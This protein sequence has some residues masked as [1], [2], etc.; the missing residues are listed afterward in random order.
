MLDYERPMTRI[1]SR[2]GTSTTPRRHFVWVGERTRDLDGAHVD[3][4]AADPEPD[5]AS[6]CRPNA[7]PDDLLRAHRQ[8]RPRP[9]AR[10]AHLHHPDGRRQ[11]SARRCR[12]SSRGSPARRAGHLGLRPHARQHLTSRRPAT[13]P[14]T[15]TTS[16]TRSAGFFEVHRALGHR[17]RRHPR[18][19]DRQRRHRVPRRLG[20]DPRRRP[21][22][23]RYESV[24]DPRLNHQQS[25]ELAFLVA[26]M[27][28]RVSAAFRADLLSDTLTA[29][30]RRYARGHGRT[31]RSATTSSARTPRSTRS[32]SGSPTCSVTRRGCSRRPGRWPTSSGCGCTSRPGRSWSATRWRTWCAPSWA[33][34]RRSPA[35]RRGPGRRRAAC[36]SAAGPLALM[37]TGAGRLPGQH[38]AGR[39]REHPQLRRRHRAADRRDPRCCASGAQE[40]GVAH[41][42]GRRAALERPR[43]VRRGAAP[44]TGASSTPSGMPSKGLG[45]PVGSVL[46]G[47]ARRWPRRGS[48][49]SATAAGCAR[50][51]ILAAA[52]LLRARPPRGAAGRRPRAGEPVGGGVRR[53]V[54]GRAWTPPLV[55]TNILVMDVSGAGWT[56]SRSGR[57][58][59]G[60]G[61]PDLRRRARVRSGWSGTSTS[62]TRRPTWR[63]TWCRDCCGPARRSQLREAGQTGQH[64][65]LRPHVGTLG[66]GR[67]VELGA[68]GGNAVR[69]E[70]PEQVAGEVRLDPDR[71]ADRRE[72][73][74]LSGEVGADV[75]GRVCAGGGR[76][77]GAAWR[78]PA[79]PT[80][81]LRLP[82]SPTSPAAVD[83][84]AGAGAGGGI[85][86][87]G[88]EPDE[89]DGAREVTSTA[90]EGA[91]AVA[92][93]STFVDVVLGLLPGRQG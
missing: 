49:A 24:C 57:R 67:V 28:G 77:G 71:R 15:S 30:D 32:R 68:V 60:A 1:D 56:G 78:G 44:T 25:L 12:R 85:G 38:R 34:P 35:S 74:D 90:I 42:P 52:G 27:L 41:A 2:T 11:R 19:A 31:P 63:S 51:A 14:A 13:R 76:R 55:E 73:R 43:G 46:V 70:E 61:R 83:E 6:R 65:D 59:S 26:E 36:S 80:T 8:G 48:G 23:Q 37:I 5:R 82:T 45:A 4:V 84:A 47:S 40:R 66:L 7:D 29:P 92:L 10:P 18:G 39:G 79:V 16:S 91:I 50:S 54:A 87:T 3:F 93:P 75:G 9:R 86:A 21:R 88:A 62:P 64:E 89:P 81:S 69:L 72:G 53:G 58:C 20:E 33:P 22:D 17:A